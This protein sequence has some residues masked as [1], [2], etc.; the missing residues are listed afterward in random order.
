MKAEQP[1]TTY[2][3]FKHEIIN[4]IARCLNMPYNVAAC[5]SSDYNYASGRLDHQ[6]YFKSIRVDRSE[7]ETVALDR[8]FSAWLAEAVRVPEYEMYGQPERIRWP[9]QWFWDGREHVDPL[10]EAAAQAKRLETGATTLAIEYAKVGLDWEE[11]FRQRAK[12][13]QL[14]RDLGLPLPK[15]AA[16]PASARDREED[17][18]TQQ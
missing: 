6:T 1:A 9:H 18:A 8:I 11:Q 15:G 3:D 12:E 10:K 13:I 14:A 2:P 4:E 5:N 17:Y 16:Q 7:L